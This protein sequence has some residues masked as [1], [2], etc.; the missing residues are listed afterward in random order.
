MKQY[1][2]IYL[3]VGFSLPN[4]FGQ[5]YMT[6]ELDSILI[7]GPKNVKYE[8]E[9]IPEIYLKEYQYIIGE[10]N[11]KIYFFDSIINELNSVPKLTR[12]EKSE[13]R[14]S[15]KIREKWNDEKEIINEF[16]ELWMKI[17]YKNE[18]LSELY[19]LDSLGKCVDIET[20][21]GYFTNFEYE[22]ENKEDINQI[23]YTEILPVSITYNEEGNDYIWV[24]KKSGVKCFSVDPEDCM[25]WCRVKKNSQSYSFLN[26]LGEKI[27]LKKCPT[28]FSLSL[29]K[30][31]CERYLIHEINGEK[32]KS[33]KLYSK[34]D[35]KELKLKSMIVLDCKD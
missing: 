24:K 7:L 27:Q 29:D 21:S 14:N 12:P 2:L 10:Y 5:I 18:L 28:N 31:K 34:N 22:I 4:L 8:G 17:V 19:Y 25:I 23:Y 11:E 3:I 33:I 13:L 35:R 9:I 32:S 6:S 26:Y 20:E 16:K 1:L 15:I 30:N